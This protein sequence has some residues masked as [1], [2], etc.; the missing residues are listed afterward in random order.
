MRVSTRRSRLAVD[1][2]T[3]RINPHYTSILSLY[4]V[5]LLLSIVVV[6]ALAHRQVQA[7]VAG[8]LA[9][10]IAGYLWPVV[11]TFP[12][13]PGIA[14]AVNWATWQPLFMAGLLVGWYWQAPAG[15]R[16]AG[17][18]HGAG[19]LRCV[20]AGYRNTGLGDHPRVGRRRG[21]PRSPGPS[22][23]AHLLPAPS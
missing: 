23:K 1:A 17:K 14:G 10:Y 20:C 9:L 7:V 15:S 16:G 3:L 11:F 19:Q 8:S 13:Y 5:L 22:P 21:N 18:P 6:S 12:L 4:V 2:L